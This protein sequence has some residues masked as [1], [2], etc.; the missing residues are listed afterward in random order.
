MIVH[1]VRVGKWAEPED[2][3][4]LNEKDVKDTHVKEN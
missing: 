1:R 4:K 2:L 3:S